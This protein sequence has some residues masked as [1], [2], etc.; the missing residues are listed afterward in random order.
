M[1]GYAGID[2]DKFKAKSLDPKLD[3][4]ES[5]DVKGGKGNFKSITALKKA[6]PSLIILL[7][8]GGNADVDDP[9]KYLTAVS[10]LTCDL[11]VIIK[12]IIIINT[13]CD[14][15]KKYNSYYLLTSSVKAGNAEI[16][17]KVRVLYFRNGKREWF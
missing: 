7:S 8:V 11:L 14:V 10:I 17:N 6:Y 1:Y 5:K 3:L 15:K 4:P 13:E 2:D 16:E 9:E 12:K